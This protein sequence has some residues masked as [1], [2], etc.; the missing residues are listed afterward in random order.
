MFGVVCVP[1]WSRIPALA[2]PQLAILNIVRRFLSDDVKEMTQEFSQQAPLIDRIGPAQGPPPQPILDEKGRAYGT[3]KRKASIARVW[4]F[5]GDGRIT[6]NTKEL[7]EYV[8]RPARRF[9]VISPLVRVGGLGK[10]NVMA[11]VQGGGATG[12]AQAIRHGIAK[13][14]QNF[15]PSFRP[16]LKEAGFITRDSR[17]VERKKPGQKK[18]RKKFQWAKR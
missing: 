17:V 3:G 14:L 12:Q 10:F 4:L 6:V 7:V 11:K 13:A 18:A 5:P 16:A 9:D 8:S 2:R 15:D 1:R